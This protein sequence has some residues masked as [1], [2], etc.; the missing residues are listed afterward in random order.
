MGDKI[1]FLSDAHLGSRYHVDSRE[2]ERRLV[3]WLESVKAEAKVIYFLG[4]IF[5]YWFEYK[6][7]VPKGYVRFLGKLAELSDAGVE[8]HFL[9]GN[10]DVWMFDYFSEELNVTF[11]R[12]PFTVTHDGKS[13]H[14]AHGDEMDN[15][16]ITY[17]LLQWGFRNKLLQKLYAAIH[18]R[19]SMG[20]ALGWSLRSRKKGLRKKKEQGLDIEYLFD[21]SRKILEQNPEVDFF[22][23]GHRHVLVDE[24]LEGGAR[25]LILGDWIHYFSYAEW[26]GTTLSL[27][28]FLEN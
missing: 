3:R 2:V 18:P 13:F 19:W 1:F 10:H 6:Y 14:L 12:R 25:L 27:K 20:F 4:D 28:R 24:P 23:Y 26:D 22:L 7:V 11:H 15:R 9:I 8:L 17:R 5:D 21:Y 16:S